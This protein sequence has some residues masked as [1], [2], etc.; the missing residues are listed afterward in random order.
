MFERYGSLLFESSISEFECR[1]WYQ[2][3]QCEFAYAFYVIIIFRLFPTRFAPIHLSRWT[4]CSAEGDIP[5]KERT[6]TRSG[7]GN[8][9]S[10]KERKIVVRAPSVGAQIR[11]I[12]FFPLSTSIRYLFIY[13]FIHWILSVFLSFHY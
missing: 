1:W 10:D 4:G 7:R 6:G 2:P 13:F 5:A 11:S 12:S 8:W 3:I 9:K